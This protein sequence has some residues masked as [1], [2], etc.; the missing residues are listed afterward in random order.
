VRKD[1]EC[2]FGILKKRWKALEYGIRFDD[3]NVVERV[4]VSCFI[5][6]NMMLTEM[7]THDNRIPV[8][9][10]CPIGTDAIWLAVPND[11]ISPRIAT[12]DDKIQANLWAKR[13][14]ALSEHVEYVSR[15]LKR[16][17]LN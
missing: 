7:E 15:E 3:I 12:R 2:T 9:R 14:H 11:G 10:G 4:F 6:H 1:V 17:R 13:R 8:G 16:R 5:L